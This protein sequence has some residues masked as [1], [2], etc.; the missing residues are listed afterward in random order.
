MADHDVMIGSRYVPGGGSENWP[1]KR[2]VVSRCVN[3][4]VRLLMR[5]PAQR[6]VMMLDCCYAADTVKGGKAAGGD[7]A[8][9][10]HRQ[11]RSRNGAGRLLA[12]VSGGEPLD[13]RHAQVAHHA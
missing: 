3:A 11:S 1:L 9:C 6:V 4:M 12:G 10:E 2:R 7:F 8:R 5:I 13:E